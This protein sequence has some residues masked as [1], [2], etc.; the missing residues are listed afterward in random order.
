MI[1][2]IVFS[3]GQIV[4][5]ACEISSR[6]EQECNKYTYLEA[7]RK[8]YAKYITSE[9]IKLQKVIKTMAVDKVAQENIIE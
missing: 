1:A 8:L 2:K 4:L 7:K 3:F 5:Q 9:V 6:R